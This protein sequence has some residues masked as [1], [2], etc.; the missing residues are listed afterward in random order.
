[1]SGVSPDY[2]LLTIFSA[3]KTVRLFLRTSE[4]PN[5]LFCGIK[6]KDK[7]TKT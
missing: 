1:V 4:N 7:N 5:R 2:Y 6:G 3:E